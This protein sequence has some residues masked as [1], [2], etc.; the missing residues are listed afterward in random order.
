MS[1]K[2]FGIDNTE[3]WN[4]CL[5]RLPKEQQD[6]YY[7]PEYYK[8]YE[9]IGDGV[10][11]CFVFQ[12]GDDIA[13]YPFL[14]NSVN[15]LG[16]LLDKEY[17][18][19]QG[20]YGYNGVVTS[21]FNP[22]FIAAFYQ[23]FKAW[24]QQ[25]N[26]IAEF[27]R[28]H[29]LLNNH[30]FSEKNM[31]VIFDRRTVFVSLNRPYSD[32]FNNYQRT[33]RKQI[34]R[35]TEKYQLKVKR[36]ENNLEILDSFLLIYNETMD[37]VNSLSYLYFNR[38]Y[39]KQLLKTTPNVC[40]V[41]YHQNEPIAAIIAFYNKSYIHGHL[42]GAVTRH[43]GMSPYSMLYDHIIRFGIE[44]S[45]RIFHFGGGRTNAPDDALLNFKLNFS[46]FTGDFFIGK[47]IHNTDVYSTTVLQ[48]EANNPDK[49]SKYKNHLLKYRS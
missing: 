6:V 3:K 45:C 36:F 35:A 31:Q 16:Y 12:K 18:D 7:T 1:F 32:I 42:G 33:T 47:K 13:L 28:F 4:E 43:L 11:K 8:L 29:P 20:A 38:D 44:K 19:I 37:R 14:I 48:W 21:S 27:T 41:V 49:L 9:E 46:Q 25:M 34:R 15:R 5:Q 17:Y 23:E 26:V 40:F 39:F 10:A 24:C 22:D 30:L 2:V